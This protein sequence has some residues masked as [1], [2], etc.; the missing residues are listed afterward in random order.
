[1]TAT[2]IELDGLEMSRGFVELVSFAFESSCMFRQDNCLITSSLI[3][4]E[5]SPTPPLNTI[6]STLGSTA[7]YEPIYF[8]IL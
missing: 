3:K 6:A 2:D 8:T 7:M 5:F 4:D 1:M